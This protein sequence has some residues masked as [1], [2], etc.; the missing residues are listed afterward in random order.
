M[1]FSFPSIAS[2]SVVKSLKSLL[3]LSM[4]L[5]SYHQPSSRYA[6]KTLHDDVSVRN[7]K[8]SENRDE[9]DSKKT[10]MSSS[11]SSTLDGQY[12][13]DQYLP[14]RFFYFSLGVPFFS[15]FL[16]HI[17]F[18]NYRFFDYGYNMKVNLIAGK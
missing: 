16:Y 4:R 6:R 14:S 13:H 5:R 12:F 2:S 10:I 18:L 9:D 11:S 15:F 7:G 8:S 3:S 1:P 17:H